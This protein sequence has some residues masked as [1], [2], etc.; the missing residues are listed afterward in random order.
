MGLHWEVEACSGLLTVLGDA[1]TVCEVLGLLECDSRGL[2]GIFGGLWLCT[3]VKQPALSK[4][5]MAGAFWLVLRPANPRV[6]GKALRALSESRMGLCGCVRVA[7]AVKA[8]GDGVPCS[9]VEGEPQ[10]SIL[11]VCSLS[12]EEQQLSEGLSLLLQWQQSW[13]GFLGF[14]ANAV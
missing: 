13:A 11:A 2:K 3:Q 9:Q 4:M 8:R 6:C 12:S 7:K 1:G 10:L 14:S 5:V